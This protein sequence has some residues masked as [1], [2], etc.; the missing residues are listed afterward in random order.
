M[1]EN[2]AVGVTNLKPKLLVTGKPEVPNEVVDSIEK[3]E[4]VPQS[5]HSKDATESEFLL[6]YDEI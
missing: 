4:A 6:Y 1:E 5:S 2:T 3:K